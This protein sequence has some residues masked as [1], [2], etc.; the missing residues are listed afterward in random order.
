M[1][2]RMSISEQPVFSGKEN[3][4][5]CLAF[6]FK[7]DDSVFPDLQQRSGNVQSFLRTYLPETPDVKAVHKRAALAE[8]VSVKERVAGFVYVKFKPVKCRGI[9]NISDAEI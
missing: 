6:G 4:V 8:T 2:N 3:T 5:R 7:N 9:L 1:A